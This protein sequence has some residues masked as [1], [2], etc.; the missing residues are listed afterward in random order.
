MKK[1]LESEVKILLLVISFILLLHVPGYFLM[2]EGTVGL[3]MYGFF[4]LLVIIALL[5]GTVTGLYSS[6]IF[7]FIIG[8][9][10]VYLNLTH[11]SNPLG[12]TGFELPLFLGYGFVLIIMILIAG[13]IHERILTL[14]KLNRRLQEENNQYVAVDVDTGFD[15]QHR[16]SLEVNMEMKRVD[17]YGGAFTLVLLQ[18]DHFAE[19]RKLYGEKETSHLLLSLGEEM[20]EV[21]RLTDRKFRYE[22]DRFALLLSHTDSKSVEVIYDKLVKRITTHRLLNKNYVTLSFRSGHIAYD[23]HSSIQDYQTLFSQVESEM[24]FREL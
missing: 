22:Q 10:L 9:A 7:I 14:G 3:L 12:F 5:L 16:M 21:M 1:L 17:R 13:R 6:L 2:K 4:I 24:V 8:S 23:Q 11:A 18:M 15:N 19:F 20:M